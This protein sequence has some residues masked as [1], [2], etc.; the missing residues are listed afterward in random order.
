MFSFSIGNALSQG[1]KIWARNFIPFTTLGVIV[2]SPLIIWIM[3]SFND[4]MDVDK[5]MAMAGLV[6][7]GS[8]VLNLFISGA[9]TYGVVRELQG[10]HASM[11]ECIAVGLRRFLPALGVSFLSV[12]AIGGATLL[13][14]I[15]GIIV[16]CMLYVAVQASVMEKPGLFGA[17]SRSRFL[18]AGNK[19]NIFGLLFVVGLITG[20]PRTI[21]E[22]VILPDP[23]H[24]ES[25]SDV[26]LY[27]YV[28]LGM[29]I[30][31]GTLGAV[32]AAV[33]YFQL[34]QDKDGVSID[35][36]ARVFE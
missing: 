16:Y 24:A 33:S 7:F 32:I 5:A 3:L 31:I 17:L 22:K 12:L 36:I 25:F 27:V 23:E 8:I 1:F 14:I 34:R 2:Y 30:V 29:S 20:I 13:L 28:T 4:S 35:E 18:T 9:V 19:M 21:I 6:V 10:Q 26:K 11:G 15:P